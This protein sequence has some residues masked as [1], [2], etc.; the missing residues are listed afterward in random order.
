MT[1]L[2]MFCDID[3]FCLWFM[4]LWK[5][6]MLSSGLRK[7][8]RQGQL[9]PSEIMTILIWFHRSNYRTF[10]HF[11]QDYVCVAL[12]QEFPH[13]VS[14][15]RFIALV[16][17]VCVPLCAY[18]MTRRG[19][20]TGIAFVD[21]TSLAVCHNRRIASH[22]VFHDLAARGK[23]SVGWFYGFKLHLMINDRG[24]L[25]VFLVTAGNIDDR[26]P[27]PRMVHELF[28]KLFGDKGYISQKLFERLLD[29]GVQLIT[30][31]RK[32]MKNRLMSVLDKVLLRKRSLIETV[33]DQLK[34]I[35]QIEHTRHRSV[36]NY[37]MNLVAGLIAYTYQEH[38]PSLNLSDDEY[39]ALY[40]AY[41]ESQPALIGMQTEPLLVM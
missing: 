16:P 6:R 21:A 27:L 5:Q 35:S 37:F 3:D 28:G 8:D 32:N 1:L 30:R 40:D 15:A 36:T 26:T 4:P 22:K 9:C 7:R 24:D 10:K 38:K 13:L 2:Q 25:L 31:I 17:S 14:Y 33:N 39:R 18:L 19:P 12:R 41:Q 20:C 34:N 29:Q 23:T 11:Y